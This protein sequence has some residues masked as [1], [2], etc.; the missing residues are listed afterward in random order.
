[1]KC[2]TKSLAF[3]QMTD[4]K[5]HSMHM[6]NSCGCRALPTSVMFAPYSMRHVVS[7]VTLGSNGWGG[8]GI[9]SAAR[10]IIY[11]RSLMSTLRESAQC[12]VDKKWKEIHVAF[13][14]K[15]K[16]SRLSMPT[17]CF[18]LWEVRPCTTCLVPNFRCGQGEVC[19]WH[20]FRA[21][22]HWYSTLR[23]SASAMNIGQQRKYIH[24]ALI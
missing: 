1:M 6:H 17:F 22:W 23:E 19:M 24:V 2:G 20:W 9:S 8:I 18:F 5:D 16:R 4:W 15:F 11:E 3:Q 21:K 7:R 14:N 12:I 13:I 10:N